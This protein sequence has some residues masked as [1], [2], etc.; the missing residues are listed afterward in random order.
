MA[1]F[2]TILLGLQLVCLL[3]L[4]TVSVPVTGRRRAKPP[5]IEDTPRKRPQRPSH[6][7][8]GNGT[9][10]IED[11]W[12]PNLGPPFGVLYCVRCECVAV[13]RKNRIVARVKCKNIKNDC[14]KPTCESP[15]LQADQ[16]CKTCPG[17]GKFLYERMCACFKNE[18]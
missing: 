1:S 4:L 11:R 8:F 2:K 18:K 5:L 14:P 3:L 9:H 10:E 17:E 6:C 13:Q 16:C 15:V 12:R 7:Q